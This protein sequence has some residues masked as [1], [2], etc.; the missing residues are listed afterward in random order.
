MITASSH[1]N[2][3]DLS[4]AGKTIFKMNETLYNYEL[5]P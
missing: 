5:S 3:E 4:C 1:A 2:E